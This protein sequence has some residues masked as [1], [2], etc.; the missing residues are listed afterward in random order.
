MPLFIGRRFV[1]LGHGFD[2]WPVYV[3]SVVG[4]M[5]MR[6]GVLRVFGFLFSGSSHQCPHN[7]SSIT[8]AVY[9]YIYIIYIYIYV[10]VCV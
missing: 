4:I 1:V 10:C 5:A 6:H 3:C 8:D 7:D 9:I 2:S